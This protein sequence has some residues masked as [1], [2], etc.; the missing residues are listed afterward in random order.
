MEIIK[1]KDQGIIIKSKNADF[2]INPTIKNGALPTDAA[3]SDF[4]LCSE[5]E[6]S[7]ETYG[8]SRCFS[9]PGE[10]E[11]K[12][13]AVHAHPVQPNTA[14]TTQ[15]LLFVIYTEAAKICYV[16]ALK[17]ELH[18]D[19]IEKIG[20]VDLLIFPTAGSDKIWH[21]TLEEIEPKAILPLLA[22]EGGLSIDAFLSKLGVTKP[23]AENKITIKS[24]SDFRSDQMAVF[25]LA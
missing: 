5:P 12:G 17:A 13:V 10:Y 2:V 9:W 19:L 7:L 18:S 20:D 22:E 11:V 3:S 15:P 8:E 14:E 4:A 24:K 6:Q 1:L 25:L 23:A 16:P 21:A